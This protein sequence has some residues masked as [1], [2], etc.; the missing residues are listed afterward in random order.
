[1]RVVYMAT[2][3]HRL[4]DCHG[5]LTF[6]RQRLRFDSDEPE[7]SFEAALGEVTIE[8]DV[9]RIRDKAWRFEIDGGVPAERVFQDWK[10][11]TLRTV[12]AP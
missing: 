1:M 6:T 3:K 2:H 9:L 11:G 10:A 5:S 8:G 12:S 7:D 4:R